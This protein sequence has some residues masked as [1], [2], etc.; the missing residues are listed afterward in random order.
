[1][2]DDRGSQMKCFIVIT[3][4]VA[5]MATC[6]GCKLLGGEGHPGAEISSISVPSQQSAFVNAIEPFI[7]QYDAAPNELKKS[8]L[9]TDRAA[10][11]KAALGENT[12]VSNWVG[13]LTEMSTTGDGMAAIE[14]ALASSKAVLKTWNNDVSDTFSGTLIAQ[15]SPLYK[16]LA[17]FNEGQLIDFSGEFITGDPDFIREAS[18]TE[19]GSMT[20]PEFI[21]RFT[22]IR[23]H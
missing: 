18:L 10:Q 9:R 5:A 22:D 11:I 23:R 1:M 2:S 8:A 16:A 15:D 14:V 17:E 4:V 19:R 7:S 20:E 12:K 21:F 3:A 13:I 6:V